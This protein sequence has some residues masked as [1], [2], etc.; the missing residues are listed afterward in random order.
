MILLSFT[1]ETSIF[2]TAVKMWLNFQQTSSSKL[3]YNVALYHKSAF[4][5]QDK[6]HRL[7]V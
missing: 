7:L 3:Q 4:H 1:T 6:A 2:E 5:E